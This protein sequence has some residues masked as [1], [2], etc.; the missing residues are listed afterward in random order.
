MTQSYRPRGSSGPLYAPHRDLA[1][2]T[3]TL[4]Q[5]AISG[6]DK[7]NR[8]PELQAELVARGI[9][10]EDILL[11]AGMFADSQKLFIYDPDVGSPHAAFAKTGFCNIP[12][13]LQNL[14]FAL[15]GQVVTGAWMHAVRD[16]TMRGEAVDARQE[17]ADLLSTGRELVR[18]GGYQVVA[19]VPEEAAFEKLQHERLA[20]LDKIT[21]QDKQIK[22]LRAAAKAQPWWKRVFS[23]GRRK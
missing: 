11:A 6:L 18:R 12:A 2:I 16:V 8:S 20:L 21:I 9:S 10:D 4:I 17:L 23:F 7:E 14:I 1:H 5:H 13:A 3:P 15:V 19:P 22:Q